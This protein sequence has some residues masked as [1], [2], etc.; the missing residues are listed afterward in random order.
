[1][2]PALISIVMPFILNVPSVTA[3]EPVT[4]FAPVN[5]VLALVCPEVPIDS[6]FETKPT[7][8]PKSELPA[9]TLIEKSE[10]VSFASRT[11]FPSLR[12]AWTPVWS[13]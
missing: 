3:V 10:P 7:T 5:V 4:E 6:T 13:V 2:F 9:S 8:V 12:Y 11:T 1:M